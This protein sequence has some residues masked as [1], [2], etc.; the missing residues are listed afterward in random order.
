MELQVWIYYTLAIL[1]LTASPG[2]MVLLCVTTSIKDGFSSAIYSAFG[3]LLAIIGILTLSFT[4][5]GLIVQS[6][7]ILFDIIK[8]SGA[9]YLIYLGYK[10]LTSKQENYEMPKEEKSSKVKLSLFI[11]GFLVG[12]SNPKAII[13]FIALLPQFIDPL[14]PLF[15]QYI[16]LVTTFAIPE[17]S[18][19]ILYSY[20]GSKSSKWFLQN[21]RAKFFNR[22]T[23]GVFI[24]AGVLLS[25]TNK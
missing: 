24:G 18:W 4:G 13:F 15:T 16:I 12:V 1:L 25:S 14:A 2:P 6:S 9:A 7:Q 17:I 8:Y 21:G 23:G 11:K 20:M 19:L 10:A 3:G 5:L 22:I